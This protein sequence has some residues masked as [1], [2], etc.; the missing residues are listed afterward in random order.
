MKIID[1]HAHY[2]HKRFASDRDELLKALPENGVEM[3]INIGCDLPSSKASVKLAEAYNH[4]YASVG[5]HPH[6]AKVFCESGMEMVQELAALCAHEKVIGYG[7]IGLDFHYDFSPRDVQRE[8]FKKQLELA[9]ELN[10]PV[11][12]HSRDAHEEVFD[13]I[14]AS[15]VRRGVVHSFSGDK[16]LALRYVDLGFY[17]GIG[18]VVTFDKTNTL[19][20]A[21]AAIPLSGILLETDCPYLT[22]APHRGK[23]N[24][25]AYLS[26]VAE[27]VAKIKGE[28]VETVC[29]Q[30]GD[31]VKTLFG[32]D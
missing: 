11:I 20:D 16:A 7:E 6:D 14:K 15:P 32:V 25:S 28:T 13:I 26:F 9:Y 30:T 4:V 2:D 22:P 29:A 17:I 24:D 1:S 27:A 19:Q 5:V 8:W 3:V 21:V 12:I 18:G 31:N 23:R 10:M